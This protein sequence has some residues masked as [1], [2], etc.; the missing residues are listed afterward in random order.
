MINHVIIL[1]NH[2][3]ALGIS[4]IANKLGLTVDLYSDYNL[5]LTRFSN[6]CTNFFRFRDQQ[7][8][9]EKLLNTKFTAKPLLIPTNDALIKFIDENYA[10]LAEK[11]LIT[12]ANNSVLNACYNKVLTYKTA[13]AYNIPIPASY[14]PLTEIDVKN[15]SSSLTF[16]ILIKPGVMHR[17][18]NSLGKKV[19][20]CKDSEQLIRNYH[21]ALKYIP[22]D[23]II[24]QELIEGG[25]KN[26]F[27]FGCVAIN[28]Q[29]KAG[30]C[31]NRLRQNPMDFGISTCYAKTVVNER[32]EQLTRS[33]LGNL[34]YFGFAEVE[35]MYDEKI[36]DFKLLE[37][38]PRFWKWHSIANKLDIN[39]LK[40]MVDF[41]EGK[42]IHEKINKIKDIIWVESISDFY[43]LQS[44]IRKGK[45]SVKESINS[46]RFK[47]E[48]ACWSGSDPLPS[49]MYLIL[50]PYLYYKR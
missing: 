38:N 16:P 44:E 47:T 14:F 10:Q 25:A 1:G 42:E 49:I 9:F 46:L 41:Y 12:Q 7:D 2:I 23:E 22:K 31:V 50:L 18:Y 15:I 24:I 17:L 11:F 30:F 39:L 21:T 36:N 37:I 32:I 48:H 8:L 6:T 20:V 35:F 43:I 19:F 45:I 34:N 27:S 28:G 33:L 4:R 40:V 13:T 3:Q 29:I 5:S 26:L